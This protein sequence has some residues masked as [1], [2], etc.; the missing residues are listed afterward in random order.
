MGGVLF[1]FIDHR[2]LFVVSKACSRVLSVVRATSVLVRETYLLGIGRIC[3][4]F[5]PEQD[6]HVCPNHPFSLFIN[7]YVG[8]YIVGLP[9]M[10]G[11]E[12]DGIVRL[13]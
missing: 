13:H 3:S 5:T 6:M 8:K 2:L 11:E 10:Y 4:V 12:L 7:V 9:V 1:L